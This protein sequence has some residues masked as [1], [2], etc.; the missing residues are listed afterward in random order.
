LSLTGNLED[1]PLLDIIQ[2]VSFSKKTG[3]LTIR[4]ASGNGAI[5]FRNG[6]VV[7]GFTWKSPPMESRDSPEEHTALLRQR[8][9][10]ALEQLVRLREG[11]FDFNLTAQVP[12]RI[13]ERDITQETLT[14]GINPQELLLN[15]AQGID[16]DR[17]DSSA[18]VEASFASPVDL[19][20]E[21]AA[22]AEAAP[23]PEPAAP[24]VA[25]EPPV[26]PAPEPAAPELPAPEP[27]APEPA[28]P[29]VAPAPSEEIRVVVLVDDEADMRQLI[30]DRFSRGGYRVLAADGPAAAAKQA[31]ALKTE[32]TRFLLVTDL[33]MP[34]TGGSSFQG[35]F[36]VVKRLWK[37][38]LRPP[39]LLMTDRLGSALRSRAR[40]MGISRVVFKPGLSRLDPEQFH[41]D[42]AAFADKLLSD[43]LPNLARGAAEAEASKKKKIGPRLALPPEPRESAQDL[44]D[45]QRRLEELR[46]PGDATRISQLVM[47]MAREVFER[48]L[49]FL[50]KDEQMRG[51]GGFGS[52]PKGDKLNLLVREV[53]IPLSEPSIFLEVVQGGKP[54]QGPLPEGRWS[55]HLMGKIG[56][57]RSS[58]V[59][60][61][62]L[63]T[64]RETMALLF[65]DNPETGRGFG[66]LEILE[67]FIDQAG[68]ALENVFLQR[69]LSVL[70]RYR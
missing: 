16:E 19:E 37:M 58:S 68:V 28:A 24:S 53:T 51:L 64:H 39:V 27:P 34:T 62:P 33:G 30:A 35:G 15:L 59:A 69:K 6:Y 9:A 40:Q 41:V 38:N 17:R 44:R 21:A 2:I 61:L 29:D 8:I 52:A 48:G 70:E 13:D 56:S 63:V 65:G 50:V 67:V 4:T 43:V 66:R 60:L 5:V 12:E 36:E 46:G 7:S 49:L 10:A 11:Q 22:P 31:R 57:F 23:A 32:G 25:P 45:L 18:A 20:E 47:L 14:E 3:F 42:T 55:Q 26:T 1:L 54:W